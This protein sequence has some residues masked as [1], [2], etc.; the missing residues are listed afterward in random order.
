MGWLCCC[1]HAVHTQH[2]NFMQ[3]LEQFVAWGYDCDCTSLFT[4]K[5]LLVHVQESGMQL[6]VPATVLVL[7]LLSYK[8]VWHP[9]LTQAIHETCVI[10]RDIKPANIFMC[11]GN[12]VKVG[13]DEQLCMSIGA[14]NV[15][16]IHFVPAQQCKVMCCRLSLQ[17]QQHG[18][19]FEC[20]LD[21]RGAVALVAATQRVP[22]R[23]AV[24][25]RWWFSAHMSHSC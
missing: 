18:C 21:V 15:L 24:L 19:C 12:V 11:P 3:F 4:T 1:K 16:C 7:Q 8:G 17:L 5:R 25:R 22:S 9:V 13:N 20:D 2:I 14:H 6:H 10:H 23:I